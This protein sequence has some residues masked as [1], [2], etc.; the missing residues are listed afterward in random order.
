MVLVLALQLL[1]ANLHNP[2]HAA[3]NGL[4]WL[5][6]STWTLL[7]NDAGLFKAEHA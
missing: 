7:G 4:I 3:A 2:Q 1:Q 5:I 6:L